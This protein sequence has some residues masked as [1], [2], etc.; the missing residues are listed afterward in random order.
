MYSFDQICLVY[1]TCVSVCCFPSSVVRVYVC[2]CVCVCCVRV[3]VHV[4]VHVHVHVCVCV[5]VCVCACVCM[6][7][8]GRMCI[9]PSYAH[10]QIVGGHHRL[11]NC[12]RKL[13][14]TLTGKGARHIMKPLAREAAQADMFVS[15]K[16]DHAVCASANGDVELWV[17]GRTESSINATRCV[18]GSSDGCGGSETWY[19]HR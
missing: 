1:V 18:Y 3:C 14:H 4:H 6:C 19:M 7:A 17:D 5:C 2:M 13:K 15:V 8:R 12:W 16:W 10:P 9:G 11:A